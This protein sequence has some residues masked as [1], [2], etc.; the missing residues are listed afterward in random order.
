MYN[1]SLGIF[2]ANRNTGKIHKKCLPLK[3]VNRNGCFFR[4]VWKKINQLRPQLVIHEPCDV[5]CYSP[6]MAIG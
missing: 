2:W 4:I 6:T 3:V 5:V 1:I